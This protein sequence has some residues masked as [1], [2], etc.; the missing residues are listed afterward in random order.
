[1]LLA[2][3]EIVGVPEVADMLGIAASTARTDLNPVYDK[4]GVRRQADLVRLV[5]RFS[6]S[7]FF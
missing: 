3:V 7:P 4:T 1:V 5:A 2:I 6:N